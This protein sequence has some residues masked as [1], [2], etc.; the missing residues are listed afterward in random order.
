MAVDIQSPVLKSGSALGASAAAS[1]SAKTMEQ[2]GNFLPNDLAGWLAAGA[3]L[4]AIL[5]TL[6]LWG[7]F[8]FKK[9]KAWKE[10]E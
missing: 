7:E 4:L 6:T 3:S 9:Y 10:G 5:Y 1:A 8:W 2:V